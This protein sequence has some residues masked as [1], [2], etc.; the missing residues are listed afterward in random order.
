VLVKKEVAWQA[1]W[2]G[3]FRVRVLHSSV[4][5]RTASGLEGRQLLPPLP[6]SIACVPHVHASSLQQRT[7]MQFTAAALR[8]ISPPG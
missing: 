1:V 4:P 7:R 2:V 8:P 6:H 5:P 3:C